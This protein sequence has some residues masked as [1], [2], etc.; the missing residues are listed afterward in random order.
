[1]SKVVRKYIQNIGAVQ[2]N[3][4][5]DLETTIEILSSHI[6]Q[7]KH[8]M[9]KQ[10]LEF[11]HTELSMMKKELEIRKLYFRCDTNRIL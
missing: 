8:E 7:F 1:M 11:L 9:T 4:I 6:H 10:S 3:R 5:Q 2:E